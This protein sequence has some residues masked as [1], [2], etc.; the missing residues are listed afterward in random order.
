[1]K[2]IERLLV[3]DWCDVIRE[4]D[5]LEYVNSKIE[6][7]EIFAKEVYQMLSDVKK[8][9]TSILISVSLF[10]GYNSYLRSIEGEKVAAQIVIDKSKELLDEKIRSIDFCKIIWFFDANYI[11]ARPMEPGYAYY[12]EWLGELWNACDWCDETWTYNDSSY[13]REQI[14]IQVPIIKKWIN[15]N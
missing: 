1:M 7:G 3:E 6:I 12:P 9:S 8:N 14:T 11:D 2:K 5:I 15:D 4:D 13:I 10:D